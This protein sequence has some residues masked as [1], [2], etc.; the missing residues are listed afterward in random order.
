MPPD[1]R[2]GIL[3]LWVAT[4][5]T[6]GG[7]ASLSCEGPAGAEDMVE[8]LCR[9]LEEVVRDRHGLD[10]LGDE[11]APVALR[12]RLVASRPTALS[13][14]LH[15]SSGDAGGESPVLDLT[16]EDSDAIPASALPGFLR[17]LVEL[18]DPP[19]PPANRPSE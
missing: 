4:A 19:L 12:L 10:P 17:S 7:Q 8:Q 5:A 16:V 14:Q 15:W 11:A 18:V 9:T 6:A 3:T 2:T 13:A 1:L